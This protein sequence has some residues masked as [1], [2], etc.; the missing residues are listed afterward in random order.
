MRLDQRVIP[1]LRLPARPG[2]IGP[3]T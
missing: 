2:T 3:K 1:G